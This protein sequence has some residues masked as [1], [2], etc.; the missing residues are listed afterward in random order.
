MAELPE[1]TD[2]GS[3]YTVFIEA[4]QDEISLL[5][6]NRYAS[7][8]K[9]YDKVSALYEKE[10]KTN[11]QLKRTNPE[12]DRS[13]RNELR[14]TFFSAVVPRLDSA[15]GLPSVKI[16]LKKQLW[17]KSTSFKKVLTNSFVRQFRADEAAGR[18]S[19]EELWGEILRFRRRYFKEIDAIVKTASGLRKNYRQMGQN[20]EATEV[21]SVGLDAATYLFEV[22][23]NGAFY[24]AKP[25][26]VDSVLAALNDHTLKSIKRERDTAQRRPVP[27][28]LPSIYLASEVMRQEPAQSIY[29][30]AD[31][32]VD[33]HRATLIDWLRAL[34]DA[35][36]K[37]ITVRSFMQ[38]AFTISPHRMDSDAEDEF[39]SRL[40]VLDTEA[41]AV[42]TAE[43]RQKYQARVRDGRYKAIRLFNTRFFR[44]S[45][46]LVM[47]GRK[48]LDD[49]TLLEIVQ[50]RQG[51]V[52][53]ILFPKNVRPSD[54]FDS[55]LPDEIQISCLLES[56]QAAEFLL[57]DT[58]KH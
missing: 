18:K 43:D 45:S 28:D 58:L 35:A 19:S 11:P 23:W 5:F 14:R 27:S 51:V 42:T 33:D 24:C 15:T 8:Q 50:D 44:T 52:T 9:L 38:Y 6:K 26:C 41:G 2:D 55:S 37:E 30:P 57:F 22:L 17:R 13:A 34:Q 40:K 48:Q 32:F 36:K 39:Y 25:T 16:N 31:T 10:S 29:I 4:R 54:G 47:I 53:F 7:P 56:L 20:A 49:E 1:L 3:V 12:L 46:G 21:A